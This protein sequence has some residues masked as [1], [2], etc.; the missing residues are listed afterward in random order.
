MSLNF[1]Q[2]PKKTSSFEFV[3]SSRFQKLEFQIDFDKKL[4]RAHFQRHVMNQECNLICI[5]Q[6]M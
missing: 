1:N 3:S 2:N 6:M 5:S 4:H